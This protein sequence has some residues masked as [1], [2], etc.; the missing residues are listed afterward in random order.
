MSRKSFNANKAVGIDTNHSNIHYTPELLA[1]SCI[2][3]LPIERN[4]L[5]VDAGAGTNKVWF[6]NFP[7]INKEHYEISE[8]R[9]FLER[10][11]P[12]DWVIGNPPFTDFIKFAEHSSLICNKGFAFLINHSR[13]NQITTTRLN[14]WLE[15]G[16]EQKMIYTISVKSWFGRYYFI[17]WSKLPI[18]SKIGFFKQNF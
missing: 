15:R 9:N 18:S 3:L 2:G 14:R 7:T 8:G 10:N 17:V 4:D 1:K 12:C 16:F 13:L 6:N 11:E 5:V